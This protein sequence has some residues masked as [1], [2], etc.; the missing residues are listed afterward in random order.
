MANLITLHDLTD[1]E[2]NH[3]DQAMQSDQHD[4]QSEAILR[5]LD[6]NSLAELE[7]SYSKPAEAAKPENNPQSRWEA[8]N[9][10]V[11]SAKA[12]GTGIV[13]G[14]LDFGGKADQLVLNTGE[15][16]GLVD[17]QRASDLRT[18][19]KAVEAAPTEFENTNPTATAAGKFVG[20]NAVPTLASGAFGN[21]IKGAAALGA[22]QGA[23][24]NPDNPV[25]GGVLGGIVGGA[26]QGTLNAV[27]GVAGKAFDSLANK[28]ATAKSSGIENPTMSML[29]P[30]SL[31]S[32][33]E[34]FLSAVPGVGTKGAREQAFKQADSQIKNLSSQALKEVGLNGGSV[35]DAVHA[36]V[37]G[38]YQGFKNTASS[39][40]QK[41][42]TAPGEFG[43]TNAK[44]VLDSLSKGS[45]YFKS[46]LDPKLQQFA[47]LP[48][49]LPMSVIHEA[50]ERV[51]DL[52]SEKIAQGLSS[53]IKPLK[54]L[55]TALN[56]DY[57]S[58]ATAA[59]VG[60][61]F[62]QANDI[63]ANKVIPMNDLGIKDLV[64]DRASASKIY[65]RFMPLDKPNPVKAADFLNSFDKDGRKIAEAG[66][67]QSILKRSTGK[68]GNLNI[69]A[70][71]DK[72]SKFSE[73][74][75]SIVTGQTKD[76]VTGVRRIL[77][78]I[79]NGKMENMAKSM[80]T[81][82][83]LKTQAILLGGAGLGYLNAPLAIAAGTATKLIS[84]MVKPE[85]ILAISRIGSMSVK[86]TAIDK[87]IMGILKSTAVN[88][89][90]PAKDDE[91][92]YQQ[93]PQAV[94]GIRG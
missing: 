4:A 63:Y 14:A 49:Q 38:S 50:R 80:Q 43:I 37:S 13:K 34:K 28:L 88:N 71:F 45:K 90:E 69:D 53:E 17:P 24:I 2:L 44:A 22:A 41:V 52:V 16:L 91:N 68:D 83:T 87:A 76:Y 3:L 78:Y 11:Q 74:Y 9:P 10:D 77:G 60:D 75:G 81:P 40:F 65:S 85:S 92:K 18:A 59:G 73:S 89:V 70:A 23:I 31:S 25:S 82:M 94:L 58:A 27:G 64:N 57:E 39:L 30:D 79:K 35:E 6:D 21:T 1:D 29:D 26:A 7:A 93:S 12:F 66:A 67:L 8:A 15:K 46:N 72:L 36:S 32:N 61:A 33:I 19:Y 54:A 47:D 62:K 86:G 5:K 48:D 84:T 55:R 56:K 51:D 42:D 20:F